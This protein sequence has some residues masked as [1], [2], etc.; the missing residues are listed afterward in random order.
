M[1]LQLALHHHFDHDFA[2]A[3]QV[4]EV[5]LGREPLEC[6]QHWGYPPRAIVRIRAPLDWQAA[7]FAVEIGTSA[8]AADPVVPI[9][10]ENL[11]E[12]VK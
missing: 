7:G 4:A 2:A 6:H 8:V 10:E 3:P 12:E 5:D 1:G 11:S 9:R